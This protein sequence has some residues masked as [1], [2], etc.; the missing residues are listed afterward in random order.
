MAVP[1]TRRIAAFRRIFVDV[2]IGVTNTVKEIDIELASDTDREKIKK[3]IDEAL[4]DDTKVLWLTDKSGR[5]IAVQSAKIAY[6]ELGG[7][8][9]S[10]RIGF[11]AA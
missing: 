5:D 6:I 7:A 1:P 3:R 10:R 8:D 4:A 9:E 11:G 2:R